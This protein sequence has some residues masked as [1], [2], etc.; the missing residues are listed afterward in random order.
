MID[1]YVYATQYTESM[2]SA[3]YHFCGFKSYEAYVA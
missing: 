1:K 3:F 2:Q